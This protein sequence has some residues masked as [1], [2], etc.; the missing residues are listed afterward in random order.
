MTLNDKQSEKSEPPRDAETQ[1]ERERWDAYWTR[2]YGPVDKAAIARAVAQ[3]D[4]A[5][6]RV[7]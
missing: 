4:R 1:R 7:A 3:V 2:E 5:V 6:E